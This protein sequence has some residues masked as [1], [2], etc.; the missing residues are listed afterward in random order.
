MAATSTA[1]GRLSFMGDS[2][3]VRNVPGSGL[4]AAGPRSRPAV[5]RLT[6]AV[7]RRSGAAHRAVARVLLHGAGLAEGQPV[8]LGRAVRGDGERRVP[9]ARR[10]GDAERAADVEQHV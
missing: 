2:S 4:P 6:A 7:R 1:M 3:W 9:G 8:A 5:A 10:G